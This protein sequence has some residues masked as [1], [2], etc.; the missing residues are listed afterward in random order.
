MSWAK[1]GFSAAKEEAKRIDERKSKG[2]IY[3]LYIPDGEVRTIRF[4]HTEPLTFRCHRV[5]KKITRRGKKKAIWARSVCPGK[6][7]CD[8]CQEGQNSQFVGAW[9]VVDFTSSVLN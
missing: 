3:D 6:K 1:R 2:G 4:L 8:L 5:E 9:L 7:N